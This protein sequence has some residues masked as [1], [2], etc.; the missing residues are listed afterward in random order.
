MP[1]NSQNA[2]QRCDEGVA[3][4][5]SRSVRSQQCSHDLRFDSFDVVHEVYQYRVHGE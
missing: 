5:A 1:D 2:M 4:V 3:V